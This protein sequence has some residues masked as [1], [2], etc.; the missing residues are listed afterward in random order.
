LKLS[1]PFGVIILAAGKGTRMKSDLPKVLHK[2]HGIS[3]VEHVINTSKNIGA[4]K[5]VTV[6]G[7]KSELVKETLAHSGIEFALQKQQLG[8]GHAVKQCEDI[9]SGFLGNI[10]VLS[11]D[12]PLISSHTLTNLLLN[13]N[14]SNNIATVLTAN[15]DNPH[16]YG[17]VIRT[18]NGN[19]SK[20]VEHKDA[21][22]KELAIDEINSGIYVFDSKTLFEMLPQIKNDNSQGEYYLPDVLTMVLEKKLKVG[23]EKTKNI[24]EIQGV[25]TIEQ[26]L[27]LEKNN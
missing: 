16:G 12:V 10:L 17:R 4:S 3:M 6:V 2:I 23:V 7:Y 24:T 15:I 26:L 11:G 14:N 18:S 9:L 25:N 20:I 13:H 22:K 8:T 27:Q 19:L 5:I 1:K 21:S